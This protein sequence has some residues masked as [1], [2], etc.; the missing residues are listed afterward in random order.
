MWE[1]D[2]VGGVA[3]PGGAWMVSC[4]DATLGNW[5]LGVGKLWQA[6][7]SYGEGGRGK[8]SWDGEGQASQTSTLHAP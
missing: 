7:I 5:E 1:G 2:S 6:T 8:G 4:M 3:L